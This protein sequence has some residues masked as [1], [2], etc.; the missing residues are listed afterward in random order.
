M[1]L[2]FNTF[3]QSFRRPMIFWM[4]TYLTRSTQHV[5]VGDY[6]SETIYCH[7]GVPQVSHLGPLFSIDDVLGIICENFR[8]L[9]YADNLK[10]YMR[11]SS[12]DYCIFFQ[13]SLGR[14]QGWCREKKYENVGPSQFLVGRNRC[15][16][17]ML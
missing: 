8:V 1:G 15:C 17:N 9:A 12:T 10:S 3:T 4:G 5:R 2:L 6:L 14:L 16:F 13:R 7:V 11:I